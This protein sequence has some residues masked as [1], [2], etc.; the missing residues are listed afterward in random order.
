MK[1]NGPKEDK[2]QIRVSID[3]NKQ[4][5]FLKFPLGTKVLYL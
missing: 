3:Y 2:E 4:N 1:G 5:F